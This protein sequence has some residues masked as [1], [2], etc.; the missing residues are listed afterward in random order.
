[1]YQRYF[2]LSLRNWCLSSMN[3]H[4][5]QV[6]LEYQLAHQT[7]VKEKLVWSLLTILYFETGLVTA[8]AKVHLQSLLCMVSK[9]SQIITVVVGYKKERA[10]ITLTPVTSKGAKYYHI[11][12]KQFNFEQISMSIVFGIFVLQGEM[13]KIPGINLKISCRVTTPSY[14][15]IN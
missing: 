6:F 3:L 14:T 1:M 4:C 11:K 8:S 13:F 7:N 12:V 15:E 2:I 9:P 5:L 10:G